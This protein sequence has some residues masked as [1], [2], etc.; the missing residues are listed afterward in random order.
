[1]A[2]YIMLSTLTDEG[3]KTLKE[4]PERLQDITNE[5]VH[6]EG[7]IDRLDVY[8]GRRTGLGELRL[9]GECRRCPLP[10]AE[11]RRQKIDRARA[12]GDADR[13]HGLAG[14]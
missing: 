13:D 12:R 7:K 1:M 6:L 5:D 11:Q 9:A 10:A 4:R 8:T 3:R 14:W 2:T